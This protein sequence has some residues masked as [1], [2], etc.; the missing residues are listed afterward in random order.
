MGRGVDGGKLR[1]RVPSPGERHTSTR[2]LHFPTDVLGCAARA[3]QHADEARY[4]LKGLCVKIRRAR[5]A[6]RSV[7]LRAQAFLRLR[8]PTREG[9]IS[10]RGIRGTIARIARLSPFFE[11]G[12]FL[13]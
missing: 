11:R 13:P 4:R 5:A 2:L 9:L 6:P 7:G 8:V 3:G 10:W 12:V 1:P